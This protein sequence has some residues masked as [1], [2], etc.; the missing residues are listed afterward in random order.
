MVCA[1]SRDL[2]SFCSMQ[3][4]EAGPRNRNRQVRCSSI[5]RGSGGS[6]QFNSSVIIVNNNIF[7]SNTASLVDFQKSPSSDFIRRGTSR[8][9]VVRG[10]PLCGQKRLAPLAKRST[11]SKSTSLVSCHFLDILKRLFLK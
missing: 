7:S 3:R 11:C 6:S 4:N 9:F 8:D 5:P 1:G 2:V 10:R